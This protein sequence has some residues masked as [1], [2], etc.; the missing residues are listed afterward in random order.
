MHTFHL[1]S[2]QF[3]LHKVIEFL[4][5]KILACVRSLRFLYILHLYRSS[6][7]MP[8]SQTVL[9]SLDVKSTNI[10]TAKKGKTSHFEELI[11]ILIPCYLK[12]MKM[13][14]RIYKMVIYY[15]IPSHIILF[16][17]T[18]IMHRR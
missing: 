13:K 6:A 17:I 8:I 9:I 7:E 15:Q 14:L 11:M 3:L 12:Y 5:V 1:L 4:R 18:P 2:A 16:H 10:Y